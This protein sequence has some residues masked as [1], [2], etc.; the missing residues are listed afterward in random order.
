MSWSASYDI[1]T[2]GDKI[3]KVYNVHTHA[4][5]GKIIRKTV[6]RN[7]PNKVTLYMIR[8]VGTFRYKVRL[9]A[10]VKNK[11]VTVSG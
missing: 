10:T 6:K 9:T 2:K 11:R 1:K 4:Y 7:K 3:I 8:S 5:T